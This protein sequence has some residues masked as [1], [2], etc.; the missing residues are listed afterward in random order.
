M[1]PDLPDGYS[2]NPYSGK[3]NQYLPRLGTDSATLEA[4]LRLILAELRP[5]AAT[6]ADRPCIW[7][8][9]YIPDWHAHLAR[10]RAEAAE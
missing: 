8:D 9:Y 7:A 10:Q 5:S 6:R 2:L 4:W 3:W 1:Q